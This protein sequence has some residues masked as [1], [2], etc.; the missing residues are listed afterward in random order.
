MELLIYVL[1][2]KQQYI[3]RAELVGLVGLTGPVRFVSLEREVGL[4]KR[5][6]FMVELP[7]SAFRSSDRVA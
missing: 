6:H 4:E 7:D 2:E 1:V 5:N 3:P